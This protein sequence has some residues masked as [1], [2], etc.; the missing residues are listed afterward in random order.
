MENNVIL[1]VEFMGKNVVVEEKL[2]PE[3]STWSMRSLYDV[4]VDGVIKHP[5]L[6]ANGAIRVLGHYLHGSKK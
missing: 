3:S 2:D 5:D 6:D 4:K 1:D